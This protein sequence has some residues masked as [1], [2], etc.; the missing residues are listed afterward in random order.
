VANQNR[1]PSGTQTV[2]KGAK[3]RGRGGATAGSARNSGAGS[4]QEQPQAG[5]GSRPG[6]PQA[7]TGSRQGQ[8]QAGT[9]SRQGQPQAATASRQGQPQAS[10]TA[11]KGKPVN[12]R[13]A[14]TKPA[15]TK[16][17]PASTKPAALL[18][19]GVG[20]TPRW[21]RLTTLGASLVGVG[22]STYLT[23]AHLVGAHILA[24]SNSG[25][26]DCAAVT[27]SPESE[28]FGIFP[29][30]ELGL[31]FYVFMTVINLPWVWRPEWRWLPARGPFTAARRR[32]LPEAAWRI[33]LG[34]VVVGVLF[35]LYL[36]YTELITLR[37]ICLW[38]T[39]VHITTFVLFII[40]LAQATFWGSPAKAAPDSATGRAVR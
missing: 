11:G 22:L 3:S 8:P 5:A 2:R 23:I 36:I 17:K 28:L 39:Y 38:C 9:A 29:V 26:V 24:C 13:P 31:A 12:A 16:P 6:Q 40:L 35:I 7:G 15:S 14:S 19:V 30:A 25:L 33:R 32:A 20:W 21:L 27:T 4:R 34:S 1:R 10:A 18:P 37:T